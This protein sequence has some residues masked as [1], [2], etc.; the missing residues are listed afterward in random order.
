MSDQ[1]RPSRREALGVITGVAATAAL[2]PARWLS[3]ETP[4]FKLRYILGSCMYGTTKLAEILP[5]VK[6][7]GAEHIDIWPRVHGDQREQIET[8]GVDRFAEMLAKHKV[9]LGIIT[10][11]KLGPYRL[12]GEMKVV[13]KLGGRMLICGSGKGSGKTLRDQVRSFAES[14]KPHIAA[15]E[16]HGLTIGIENHGGSLIKTPDSMRWFV[17]FA[18][19]KRIGIALAP[20]HLP[21][22]AKMMGKLIEDL[23][24][25]LVHFYAWQHGHG[26][27]KKLP[28]EEELLQMPGRG[29]LDFK[30]L[31]AALKKIGYRG[32]TEIF[33][34]PV[35]RGIPILEPTS[36]ATD[37]IRRA[38][39]YLEKLA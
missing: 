2:A 26:C 4:G 14:M 13:K 29:K 21:Q 15:A 9:K 39:K 8:M 5:E 20:Y 34:H 32:W 30:P 12:Q 16:K 38:R 33:M 1:R 37:E 35:P 6:K 3:A 24:P 36:K 31:L 25:R 22:D 27:S 7:T 28:K 18:K 11:Y 10:Q 19:S 23:G 17:E